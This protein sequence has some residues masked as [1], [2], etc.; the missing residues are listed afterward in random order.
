MI[1]AIY[2]S[3]IRPE[4]YG[5]FMDAWDD[6]IQSA[7]AAQ[8]ATTSDIPPDEIEIDPELGAHFVRAY[9]ILEQIG[10]R[11]DPRT[12]LDKY[13][14]ADGFA[15]VLT[16]RGKHL[17]ASRRAMTL[18]GKDAT[19]STLRD[20]LT[21][22]SGEV[23]AQLVRAGLEGEGDPPPVVLATALEPRHL[24][25]RLEPGLAGQGPALVIEAMEYHWSAPAE[26]MLVA[27][28]GL[29][30]A[31]VDVVRQLLAGRDITL[32]PLPRS[33]NRRRT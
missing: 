17:A 26:A 2:E 28:F 30:R 13:S 12:P 22:T 20:E 15:L 32:E 18:L 1:A 5:E 8:T 16:L 25:A 24:M 21:G 6:H 19:L 23:L 27:S 4:L 7:I 3:V 31:E 11:S 14:T 29:S 33:A 10:R 9:E